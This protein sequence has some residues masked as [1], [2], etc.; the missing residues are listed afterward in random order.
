MDD[1]IHAL[2][3]RLLPG[4]HWDAVVQALGGRAP[5]FVPSDGDALRAALQL[6]DMMFDPQ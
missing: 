4:T 1:V 5:Q 3:A 2:V 6:D